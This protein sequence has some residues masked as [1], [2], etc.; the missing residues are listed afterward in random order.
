MALK[1]RGYL[2]A[3]LIIAC[4]GPTPDQRIMQPAKINRQFR[5][6]L[7]DFAG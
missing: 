1:P 3:R 2:T 4:A 5:L 7:K 6:E